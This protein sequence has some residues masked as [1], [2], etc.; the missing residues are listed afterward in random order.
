MNLVLQDGRQSAGQK[1][2]AL[3]VSLLVHAVVIWLAV[4]ARGFTVPSRAPSEYKQK[5][6][7]RD[8]RLVWYK[9]RKEL[10]PVDP[11]RKQPDSR[12]LR[13][14]VKAAQAIVSSP[15]DAPKRP[16]MVWTPAPEL[17]PTPLLESPNILAVALPRRQLPAPPVAPHPDL[18]RSQLS[19]DTPAAEARIEQAAALPGLRLPPKSFLAPAPPAR[20]AAA[21]IIE[22]LD[23]PLLTAGLSPGAGAA[24]LVQP[25]LPPRPFSPP[26]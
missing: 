16:Q 5:I 10:P 23:A 18:A 22:P 12:P 13:A 20:I 6:E 9:F 4:N 2:S 21:R 26:P 19:A 8:A 11:V 3:A 7:G 17:A 25:K 14:E 1:T 24:A 15:K